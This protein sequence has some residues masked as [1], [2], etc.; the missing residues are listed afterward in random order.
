[1][2]SS[3]AYF[4]R[5]SVSVSSRPLL[6]A[7]DDVLAEAFLQGQV[8]EVDAGG[9]LRGIVG[10]EVDE[11]LQ[12]V[13][14][15]AA[16]FERYRRRGFT[17]VKQVQRRIPL[18][19]GDAVLGEDLGDVEDGGGH[20]GGGELA[21]EDGVEHLPGGGLEAEADVAE[22][23]GELALGE[24][25]GD[26]AGAFDGFEA[27]AF[28]LFHAGGDREDQGVEHEVFLGE[29]VMVDGQVV[30]AL[31]DGE[32]AAAG[33]GHGVL[34]VLVDGAE[35]EA[36]RRRFFASLHMAANLSSPSSRFAELMRHF[37]PAA[38]SPAS[39]VAGWVESSMSGALT[40]CTRRPTIF[41]MSAALS[42]PA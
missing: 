13:G 25:L 26:E 34:G 14:G 17:G 20:A 8:G 11:N 39:I 24:A 7:V 30:H 1:M 38:L 32:L 35:D 22:P 4:C 18:L 5:A 29:A 16:V 10:E 15:L 12:G 28:V 37:P 27:R 2:M 41:R 19:V 6:L 31:G 40:C 9:L 33:S 23:A 36:P 42:R 3:G 21:E